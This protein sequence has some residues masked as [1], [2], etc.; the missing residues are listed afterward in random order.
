VTTGT[1]QQRRNV[2]DTAI[3]PAS[4]AHGK[5]I[6]IV[7]APPLPRPPMTE[8]PPLKTVADLKL[9]RYLGTWYEITPANA[10]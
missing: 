3:A 10:P 5:A 7:E 4:P 9:P 2:L 6:G 1:P 8:H